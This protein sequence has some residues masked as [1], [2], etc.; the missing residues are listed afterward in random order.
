MAMLSG[1]HF[2]QLRGVILTN[3]HPASSKCVRFYM[4]TLGSRAKKESTL[5][6]YFLSHLRQ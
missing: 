5:I 3:I 2:S 6:T 1:S 4:G